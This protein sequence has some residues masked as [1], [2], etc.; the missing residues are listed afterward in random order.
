M[1]STRPVTLVALARK[2]VQ[3]AD[4]AARDGRGIAVVEGMFVSPPTLKAARKLLDRAEA[5][6]K[7]TALQS[8]QA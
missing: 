7:L 4:E 5:I 1:R 3:A 8:S 2:M 6:E